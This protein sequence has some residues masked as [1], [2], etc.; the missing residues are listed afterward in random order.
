[1]TNPDEH[2]PGKPLPPAE[3]EGMPLNFVFDDGLKAGADPKPT[4][5][6]KAWPP[7]TP[8]GGELP[9]AIIARARSASPPEKPAK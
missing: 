6:A 4:N 3:P 8:P 9:P 7:G 2:T 1:M 5:T